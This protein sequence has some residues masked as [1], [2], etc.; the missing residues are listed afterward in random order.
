MGQKSSYRSKT[1]LERT[2]AR[3]E[4]LLR[5][6]RMHWIYLAIGA[7]WFAGLSALGV[8]LDDLIWTHFES[9]IPAD[10]RMIFGFDFESRSVIFRWLGV[11]GGLF[12]FARHLSRYM[13]TRVGLTNRRLLIR[14]G[15]IFVKIDELDLEEIKSAHINHGLLGRFLNY[16]QLHFDARFVGD[17]LFPHIARPY[18]FLR[19]LHEICASLADSMHDTFRSQPAAVLPRGR[20]VRETKDYIILEKP[21]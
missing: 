3:D 9:R 17:I 10:G 18:P 1:F 13:T 19:A 20:M 4:R 12:I 6:A 21:H 16:G 5:V 7:L 2:I 11:G 15:L 14:T 8:L